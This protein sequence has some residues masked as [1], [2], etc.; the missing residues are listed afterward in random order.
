MKAKLL[1][2]PLRP[3]RLCAFVRHVGAEWLYV[4]GKHAKVEGLYVLG[5]RVVA[6]LCV[7]VR[8]AACGVY[9]PLRHIVADWAY[10]HMRRNAAEILCLLVWHGLAWRHNPCP[11]G[12]A[13]RTA[14]WQTG[15]AVCSTM[16]SRG[17]SGT[18]GRAAGGGRAGETIRAVGGG[19][20]GRSGRTAGGGC[21]EA[22]GYLA[23]GRAGYVSL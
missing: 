6:G 15:A 4:L 16:P 14:K 19:C 13:W 22:A 7:R 18:A 5:R 8:L 21:A 1:Y 11:G 10:V 3:D 17:C 2:V 12:A 9:A 23:V 20:V